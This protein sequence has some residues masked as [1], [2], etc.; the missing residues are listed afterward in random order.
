VTDNAA[1]S[2]ADPGVVAFAFGD[3]EP[4]MSRRD[5]L[6]YLE[7]WSNG[8]WYETPIS[9]AALARTLRVGSHHESAIRVKVN[10]LR[11]T[12]EPTRMLS[13][14]ALGALA[15]D[16]LVFGN[17]YP[18]LRRAVTG[19]AHH[20]ERPLAKYV[21]RGLEPGELF[22]VHGF[23][24]FAGQL[25]QEH[26]FEKGSVHQLMEADVHQDIYGLPEYI[27]ALQSAFLNESATIF[28]RRYYDNGSHAG[29]I[30]LATDATLD[31]PS[32]EK[33]KTALK[34]SKG[35]GNF[36]NMFV[37]MPNGK[38]ESLKLI[39]ISEVAAKDEFLGV[40]NTSRDDVLAAHRVPPQIL[41]IVPA[42]A[43][44]F[45]DIGKATD[46]FFRNEIEPLQTK[47]EGINDWL[48]EEVVRWRPWE[49]MSSP[50]RAP[51]AA[52]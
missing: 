7:C 11:R 24:G 18:E 21:R 40:K 13:R 30:L 46:V 33:I 3:P 25:A 26:K 29:F 19:R 47:F 2:S 22:Q 16:Y 23:V 12:F 6:E 5:L 48:G 44:G 36:R 49:P 43:G 31:Q 41:G 39:P 34:D 42:N 37:H 52:A 14:D 9:T 35:V 32:Q 27:S 8:R 15:L 4:V 1:E 38:P 45:G 10:L 17:A 51:G 28:R 20:V 50:A